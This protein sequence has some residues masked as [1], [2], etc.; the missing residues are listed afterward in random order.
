M[1]SSLLAD[2][3]ASFRSTFAGI[4]RRRN[5][6]Y[7]E[8]GK[9]T[10]LT[11]ET[12]EDRCLLSATTT[13]PNFSQIPITIALPDILAATQPKGNPLVVFVGDSIS[14]EYAYGT[15]APVWSANM[16]P[17]GMADYGVIG[18]TTQSLLF[19][20]SLGL[21]TNINPAVVVLDIGGNDLLQ[22]YSPA[23]TAAGVLVDV[24]MIQDYLPQSQVIVLGILPGEQSPSAPYR[25][26]GALTNQLVSQMLAGDPRASFV[27]IGSIFVQ[28]DGTI[29]NTMMFDY[30]HPTQLGYQALTNVLMPYIDQALF[31]GGAGVS[32]NEI[33][34]VGSL[35]AWDAT[36]PAAPFFARGSDALLTIR[37]VPV[38]QRR[39]V[40]A[41]TQSSAP[42]TMA[43]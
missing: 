29:S 32:S 8:T 9:R 23:D 2:V 31:P 34:P 15:G 28:P 11:V 40:G 14:W 18:Q 6:R 43:I 3:V 33:T 7:V 5:R 4:R 19:Q 36:S 1:L 10:T 12:L 37:R 20:L 26:Q 35:S 17:L 21:L 25:S 13:V 38:R 30:L 39:A 42:S 41:L 22:G 16:A 27:D 24:A